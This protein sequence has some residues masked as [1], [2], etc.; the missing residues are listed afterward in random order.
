MNAQRGGTDIHAQEVIFCL[1]DIE[2]HSNL[3]DFTL[4]RVSQNKWEGLG[5]G[6]INYSVF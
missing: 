5:L 4:C 2:T 6:R 1:A 3:F